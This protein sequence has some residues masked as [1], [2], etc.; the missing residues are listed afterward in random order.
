MDHRPTTRST[1][2]GS[3][4]ESARDA[5]ARRQDTALLRREGDD[6]SSS[7]TTP[8]DEARGSDE[9]LAQQL[10]D[11]E[12]AWQLH[13]LELR[14]Q[15]ETDVDTDDEQHQ[16]G[17]SLPTAAGAYGDVDDNELQV[18]RDHELA[19]YLALHG[20]LPDG[21]EEINF[22]EEVVEVE[23]E[24]AVA[25]SSNTAARRGERREGSGGTADCVA[26]TDT[27]PRSEGFQ[28]PC[29]GGHFYCR[30]CLR[31]LFRNAMQ[32][33]ALFPP[34][35]CTYH[36][37]LPNV[38]AL[39]GG[40]LAREFEH[41]SIELS[42]E[43]RTYCS[44]PQ[45]S[46]FIPPAS[47]AGDIGTCP[48]CRR[49][50]CTICKAAAHVG[51]DCPQDPGLQEVVEMAER[52]GWRRC[53]RCRRMVEMSFG[54][55]HMTCRCGHQ[56]CIVCG[57]QWPTC[58]C[59]PLQEVRMERQQREANPRPGDRV[60]R[61]VQNLFAQPQQNAQPPNY[62]VPPPNRVP[63]QYTYHT[64]RQPPDQ[65]AAPAPAPP[66]PVFRPQPPPQIGGNAGLPANN[67][68]RAYGD[69]AHP[70]PWPRYHSGYHRCEICH[71][72]KKDPQVGRCGR[73]GLVA[74]YACRRNRFR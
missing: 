3:F 48:T 49:Q 34:R 45:C 44:H 40:E 21:D 14:A 63:A 5:M 53:G 1:L 46:A 22:L 18:S 51:E 37:P 50:T 65:A 74:C 24:T 2:G 64:R 38:R 26:C 73:C 19:Q 31:E 66:S 30:D 4:N 69:C 39:L 43:D 41:R 12:F 15:P 54:C 11:E 68:Q 35:C 29:G 6:S 42:A 56:F 58:R 70:K 8:D 62:I 9:E 61:A 10:Q 67:P 20:H 57:R 47:V 25:E 71:K 16:G 72:A 36:I 52:E 7:S 55:N 13:F 27:C 33:E 23:D 59:R 32:D 60:P 17:E 28:A